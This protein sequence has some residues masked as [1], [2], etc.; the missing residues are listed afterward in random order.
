MAKATENILKLQTRNK[1]NFNKKASDRV[2]KTGENL[3]RNNHVLSNKANKFSQKLANTGVE[4]KIVGKCS[5]NIYETR[6]P[7][8]KPGRYNAKDLFN[9]RKISLRPRKPMKYPA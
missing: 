9:D 3:T 1:R 2:I 7:N 4:T 5:A 6:D 8:G